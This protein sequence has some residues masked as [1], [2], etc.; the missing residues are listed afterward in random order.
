MG[1][2][3]KWPA[4]RRAA[5]TR[6][7]HLRRC[8]ALN[9]LA[10]LRAPPTQL[11]HTCVG[12]D[13]LY[14]QPTTMSACTWRSLR[15]SRGLRAQGQRPARPLGA[16]V[17]WVQA[18]VP[19]PPPCWW[20][21]QSCQSR[22]WRP[23]PALGVRLGGHALRSGAPRPLRQ[24]RR[25]GQLRVHMRPQVLGQRSTPGTPWTAMRRTRRAARPYHFRGH[26]APH[27]LAPLQGLLP[28]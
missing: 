28:P 21:S 9:A 11:V 17:P 13:A 3:F 6:G 18:P 20:V 27:G 22:C 23:R 15:Q 25:P 12:E 10:P 1:W 19:A 5:S 24:G 7:C 26:A 2:A 14:I 16:P 4:R 8:D